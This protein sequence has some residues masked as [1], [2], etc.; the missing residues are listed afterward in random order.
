MI[1]D[2]FSDWWYTLAHAQCLRVMCLRAH[3]RDINCSGHCSASAVTSPD[4]AAHSEASEQHPLS[5]GVPL[6][7]QWRLIV[8]TS[9]HTSQP[10]A[11]L[12]DRSFVLFSFVHYPVP[13]KSHY[14]HVFWTY[15]LSVTWHCYGC[16]YMI[17]VYV[18]S[19]TVF[20]RTFMA[21]WVTKT[22]QMKSMLELMYDKVRKRAMCSARALNID[23]HAQNA[24]PYIG[25]LQHT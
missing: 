17:P 21:L 8:F 22:K 3:T 19:I 7:A 10:P 6:A 24:P 14:T 5:T 16:K 20:F 15:P 13:I 1:S 25:H 12:L 11:T 2:R 9:R 18:R 23:A 4:V